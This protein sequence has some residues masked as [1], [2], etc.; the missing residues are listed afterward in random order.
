MVYT[1]VLVEPKSMARKYLVCSLGVC[2]RERLLEGGEVGGVVD[3]LFGGLGVDERDV[4]F[5]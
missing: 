1:T 3:I 2:R 4:G 5:Y